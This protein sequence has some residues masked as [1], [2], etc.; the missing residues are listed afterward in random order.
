M[1]YLIG[2]SSARRKKIICFAI[3]AI[4]AII[5]I[6][7]ILGELGVFS[8]SSGW[9]KLPSCI[10]YELFCYLIRF[11]DF[12]HGDVRHGDVR[13][14]T[15]VTGVTRHR[16]IWGRSSQGHSSRSI[17]NWSPKSKRSILLVTESVLIWSLVINFMLNK[18]KRFI[19]RNFLHQVMRCKVTSQNNVLLGVFYFM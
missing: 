3:L 5:I 11:Y 8:S 19:W 12:S 4:V 16:Q 9:E 2:P 17:S 13:H 14:A 18:K 6:L 15:F 1:L 10:N 7:V